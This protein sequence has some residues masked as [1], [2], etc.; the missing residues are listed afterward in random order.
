MAQLRQSYPITY[1]AL[2]G[3]GILFFSVELFVLVQII[4]TPC[5]G[6]IDEG[7]GL[8]YTPLVFG[9]LALPVGL[10]GIVADSVRRRLRGGSETPSRPDI[11]N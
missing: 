10:I 4:R 5:E 3:L 7:A 8:F 1:W 2:V 9:M 11:S 6:C